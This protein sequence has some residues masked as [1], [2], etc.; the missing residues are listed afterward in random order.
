[1]WSKSD[2]MDFEVGL[3]NHNKDFRSILQY[4][5]GASG[6]SLKQI[7]EFFYIWRRTERFLRWDKENAP[8]LL[9]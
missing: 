2:I 6:K 3:N 4:E 9:N 8:G 7:I 5:M 1:M